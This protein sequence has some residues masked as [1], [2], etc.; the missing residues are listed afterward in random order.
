[1]FCI[2]RPDT[3]SYIQKLEREREAREKGEFKDNRS[4]FAKY[5]SFN[6]F[7][8]LTVNLYFASFG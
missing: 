6:I 3:A 4:F 7:Y 2:S 1:M 5:V 8:N